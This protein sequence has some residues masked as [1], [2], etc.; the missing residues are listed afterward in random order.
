MTTQLFMN[1]H[2]DFL[3][4]CTTGI[5]CIKEKSVLT[6]GLVRFWLILINSDTIFGGINRTENL[7]T[8]CITIT[9]TMQQVSLYWENG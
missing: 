4:K 5:K 8:S 1:V 6:A 9:Q 7:F 3:D 2:T